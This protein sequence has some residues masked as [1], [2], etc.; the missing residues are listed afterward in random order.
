[1]RKPPVSAFRLQAQGLDRVLGSIEADVMEHIWS[2]DGPVTIR[3]V[4]QALVRDRP[5]SFNTV[6]SVMNHLVDK[7]IL[8]RERARRGH[9]FGPILGREEFLATVSH[10]VASGLIR[11]FGQPAVAQFVAALREEDPVAL[12]RLAKVLQREGRAD[13]TG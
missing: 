13:A 4:H 1:M 7:G 2:G 9:V 5:L 12:T 11:D 8:R 10:E 6:V 3:A